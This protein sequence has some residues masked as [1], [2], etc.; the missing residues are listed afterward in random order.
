[1]DEI[2]TPEEYYKIVGIKP[3][4]IV[5]GHFRSW[6]NPEYI[7]I[8]GFASSA[9]EAWESNGGG[10]LRTLHQ[11][12]SKVE[13]K[14][15]KPHEGYFTRT[16]MPTFI[17]IRHLVCHVNSIVRNLGQ[18]KKRNCSSTLQKNLVLGINGGC[19]LATFL[20]ESGI[21]VLNTIGSI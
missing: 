14:Q 21:N 2:L 1:M 19:S 6:V 4:V 7:K 5:D 12:V 16:Q 13:A 15:K 9:K 3:R 11:M 18:K 8:Y 20:V 10:N 17:G